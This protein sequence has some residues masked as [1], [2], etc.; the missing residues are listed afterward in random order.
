ML[1]ILAIKFLLLWRQNTEPIY[2][3]T[4]ESFIIKGEVYNVAISVDLY[5]D[6]GG[7]DFSGNY[8]GL[9][10][11]PDKGTILFTFS[12][13]E[14]YNDENLSWSVIPVKSLEPNIID[15]I[16]KIILKIQNGTSTQY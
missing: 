12:P 9:L 16:N 2:K 3:I 8:H 4:V 6:D 11:H 10:I 13:D 1:K 7:L 5:P 15:E 14:H